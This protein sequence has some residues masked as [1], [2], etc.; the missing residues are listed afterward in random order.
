MQTITGYFPVL[1]SDLI[2]KNEG[3][4]VHRINGKNQITPIGVDAQSFLY[5]STLKG[6]YNHSQR[7]TDKPPS[8][9]FGAY[10]VKTTGTPTVKLPN[11]LLEG[12][13]VR[14][15]YKN[16]SSRVRKGEMLV[17]NYRNVNAYLSYNNGGPIEVLSELNRAYTTSVLVPGF[18]R[19]TYAMAGSQRNYGISLNPE[20]E[21]LSLQWQYPYQE[22]RTTDGISPYDV[23]FKD[24]IILNFIN[25]LSYPDEIHSIVTD[26]TSSANNATLDI[27]T[28]LAELP[29][30]A[31]MVLSGFQNLRKLITDLRTNKMRFAD[32]AKRIKVE[33]TARIQKANY[34]SRIAFLEAKSKRKKAIVEKHRLQKIAQIKADTKRFLSDLATAAASVELTTRYG[35]LPLKY[36]VD[37]FIEMVENLEVLYKRWSAKVTHEIEPPDMPGFTKTGTILVNLRAFIKRQFDVVQGKLKALKHLSGSL[38]VTAWELVPLSFVIDWF[39]NVGNILQSFFGNTLARYKEAAT[40]SLKIETSK[41]IYVHESTNASVE[42]EFAG[43][44][45]NVINPRDYCRFVWD[46]D[47]TGWRRY[48]AAALTWVFLKRFLTKSR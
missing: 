28:T 13:K 19:P 11:R 48:D 26:N 18:D 7:L 2:V 23:G 37:S 47:V 1:G 42:V 29:E 30:S 25:N 43:Y 14:F 21:Y 34:E 8:N 12:R 44:M 5:S 24:S 3:R 4:E 46:P 22:I 20:R 45:R 33:Q 27:L 31:M 10:S 40:I 17:S 36:T 6:L 39:V 35:I 15:K 16:F 38:I 32:K 41:V 9:Y